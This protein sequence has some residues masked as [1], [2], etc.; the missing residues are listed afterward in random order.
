M[1]D[2]LYLITRR[3]M[4]AGDRAVQAAHVLRQFVQEEPAAD[5]AWFHGSN[6]LVLL[7]AENESQLLQLLDA[8]RFEG[9]PC[10]GFYEPDRRGEL[11]SVAL[12]PSQA[13]R[14]LSGAFTLDDGA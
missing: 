11:T 14:R 1:N 9:T 2:K 8:A 3:D 13:T 10:C 6:I 7:T 4:S 12:G 5:A